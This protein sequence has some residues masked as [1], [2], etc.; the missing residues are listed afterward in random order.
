MPAAAAIRCSANLLIS[1]FGCKSLLISEFGCKSQ[2]RSVS[3]HFLFIILCLGGRHWSALEQR[4]H[5]CLHLWCPWWIVY[6]MLN[7]V[8]WLPGTTKDYYLGLLS[9]VIC[10]WQRMHAFFSLLKLCTQI[11][12][13]TPCEK[14]LVNVALTHFFIWVPVKWHHIVLSDSLILKL[15]LTSNTVKFAVYIPHSES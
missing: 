4:L 15:L 2:W 5:Q 10:H 1:E 6:G 3:V 8:M 14:W 12:S 13:K 9:D 11:I 7:K